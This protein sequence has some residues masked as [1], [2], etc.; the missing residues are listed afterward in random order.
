M[1]IVFRMS[2]KRPLEFDIGRIW[3][4]TDP[5]P[6]FDVIRSEQCLW[7]GVISF[8]GQ[9]QI[10]FHNWTDPKE[11]TNILL[12]MVVNKKIKDSL[13]LINNLI[14]ARIRRILAKMTVK[15]RLNAFHL[16]IPGC[17][18]NNME[19]STYLQLST[20]FFNKCALT[21]WTSPCL[22]SLRRQVVQ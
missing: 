12:A 18:S 22:S 8:K 21:G 14:T 19:M 11:A 13:S 2:L 5:L 4:R 16:W 15:V 20:V 10:F 7:V 1:F 6:R 9:N 17:H 3:P